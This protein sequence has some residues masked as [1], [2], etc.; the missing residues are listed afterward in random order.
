MLVFLRFL[1]HYWGGKAVSIFLSCKMASCVVHVWGK[2]S[3]WFIS[4]HFPE[5]IQFSTTPRHVFK[6]GASC[7]FQLTKLEGATSNFRDTHEAQ[8]LAA[9]QG[10]ANLVTSSIQRV[11]EFAKRVPGMAAS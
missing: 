11:V 7:L 8:R 9:F 4:V 1:V 3:C 10:Y 2:W 5:S 6:K